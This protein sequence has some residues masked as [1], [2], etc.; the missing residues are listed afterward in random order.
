MHPCG[1]LFDV[2]QSVRYSNTKLCQHLKI[3][4][5]LLKS[6]RY[7][8]DNQRNSL[9]MGDLLSHGPEPVIS[10]AALV[11]SGFYGGLSD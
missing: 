6:Y 4:N 3:K 9:N 1:M 2:K 11:W 5:S 8:R 10:L 7:C